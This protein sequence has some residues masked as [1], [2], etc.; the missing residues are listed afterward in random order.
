VLEE[1]ANLDSHSSLPT[2][3]TFSF[4]AAFAMAQANRNP[5]AHP[6]HDLPIQAE[7]TRGSRERTVGER[8]DAGERREN[9]K[10]TGSSSINLNRKKKLKLETQ[11]IFRAAP[12]A[13]KSSTRSSRSAAARRSSMNS[14][15]SVLQAESRS[16]GWGIRP[17]KK[18]SSRHRELDCSFFSF[19]L[20]RGLFSLLCFLAGALFPARSGRH[21]CA[22]KLTRST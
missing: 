18:K 5:A 6:W 21:K 8:E 20:S 13:R 14:T 17:K 15:R 4:P 11:S 1:T 2:F 3:K 12:R 19:S 9:R 10:E 16:G 22:E 7:V